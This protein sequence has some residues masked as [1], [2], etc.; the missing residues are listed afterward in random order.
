MHMHIYSEVI[1]GS[2]FSL[3]IQVW[4]SLWKNA[5]TLILELGEEKSCLRNAHLILLCIALKGNL[6]VS[7]PG[8]HVPEF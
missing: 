6:A 2:L 7:H 3:M 4:H 8:I 1:D 5:K